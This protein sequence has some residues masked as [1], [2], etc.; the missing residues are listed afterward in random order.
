VLTSPL[1]GSQRKVVLHLG[2]GF[3][4]KGATRPCILSETGDDIG[5]GYTIVLNGEKIDVEGE[6]TPVL[7]H[8]LTHAVDPEF[9]KDFHRL[10]GPS[11]QAAPLNAVDEYHL[12]SE[13]RA[14]PAMWIED[15]R[16]DLVQGGYRNPSVSIDRYRQCSAEFRGFWNYTFDLEEQTK[17]HFRKIV[18]DLRRR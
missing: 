2:C 15:L 11:A 10:N 18:E 3:R 1:D 6:L 14:F 7:L 17:D 4:A 5:V 16:I 13:Q 9:D 8:E 12:P